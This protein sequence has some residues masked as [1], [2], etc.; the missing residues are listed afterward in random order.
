MNFKQHMLKPLQDWFSG[1]FMAHGYCYLWKSELVWLHA[2]SDFLIALAYYSIPLMLVYFVRRRHDLPFQGIFFLFSAFILSC[3]TTHLLEIWTLWHPDYWLSGLMKAI[4]AIVSLYTASELMPLIPKALGMTSPAQLEAANLALEHEIAEHKQTVEA[5][6]KS[7]QRLSLLV[8]QTPMAVIEWTLDARVSDWNPAAERLF[9]YENSEAIGHHAAELMVLGCAEEQF[10][11]VWQ[12]LLSCQGGSCI[13]N[14]HLTQDGRTLFCDWHNI[15]LIEPNG[16]VIGVA[17]L[18]QDITQRKEAEDARKKAYEELE[19]RVEERTKEL[20][21]ANEVLLAEM[22]DRQLAESAL[23]ESETR[24]HTVVTQ[25][26]IILYATDSNGTLTLLEGKGLEGLGYQAGEAIGQS[27][28]DLYRDKLEI[29]ENLPDVLAGGDRAWIVQVGDSAYH[30][31]TTPIRDKNDQVT[32]LIGVATDITLRYQAQ[33]ALAERERYLATLVEVQRRLL[34]LKGEEDY[35]PAI[36]KLLGQAADASHV[37][38]FESQDADNQLQLNPCG[39]WCA[40]GIHCERDSHRC[41]NLPYDEC[42]PQWTQRL[43]LGETILGRVKEF[44]ESERFVLE[45]QGVLSLLVLPLTVK[46]RFFGFIVFD[47]CADTRVWSASE[48]DLLRA[49]AAALSLQHERSKAEVALRRSEAQLR[50]QATQ[51]EQ[52]LHQLKQAQA[53]LVQSEKMSSLG[54]MVAGIAHEINNPVCFVYGNLAPAGE[55]IRELLELVE[56]YRQHYPV[57]VPEIQEYAEE[58]EVD[59]LVKDLPDLLASMKV[60]AERIRD[61][62]T[63]LRTFS[64]L[65]EA[66]MKRVNI[67]EGLNSTLLILQHRLKEKPGRPTIEVVKKYGDLPL[68]ECYSGQLNQVFTNILANAIDALESQRVS[69]EQVDSEPLTP[70]PS[71]RI[72]IRTEVVD[73]ADSDLKD[74]VIRI[75]DNGPGMT[76]RVRLMLFDPFFTTK[77]VGQG[78]GLGLS[79]SYQ[80]VVAEHGG[81]LRCASAPG[82]GTEFIIQIPIAQPNPKCLASSTT[83]PFT[84]CC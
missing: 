22:S 5:L 10:N 30:N 12:A 81:Q 79:I 21:R 68:I 48:V 25:A 46:E 7:Q 32:G 34:A 63:S 4:T 45:Q 17:S 78:T 82:Q 57:P 19:Q 62:V 66:K 29:L 20:A 51:L 26:P 55:Y 59:F 71:P 72:E 73:A 39:Y 52:T 42:L 18:V 84:R 54:L 43:A 35:H 49:A 33:L 67:H 64:R 28:F 16:T 69:S 38:V 37:Y 13:T 3:G 61:I 2:G 27:D 15:P 83:S 40:T 44:P 76:E 56:L 23:W 77:P 60:G 70:Y 8:Q 41:Q 6:E 58:I 50:E 80:I 14:E 31:R 36:L 1:N 11:K 75:I 53:Q 65:D 47:N 9:G 74:V 24:L